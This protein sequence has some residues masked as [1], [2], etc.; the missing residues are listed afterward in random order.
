MRA[1]GTEDNGM[2]LKNIK[3]SREYI[4]ASEYVIDE[5]IMASHKGKWAEEIYG[6]TRPLQIEIG[7]SKSIPP[8]CLEAFRSWKPIRY[9]I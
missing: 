7:K 6:N 1:A 2:R 8:H 4:A 5:E 9:R 3:G